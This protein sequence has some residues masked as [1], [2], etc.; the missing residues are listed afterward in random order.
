MAAEWAHRHGQNEMI[1]PRHR[2][3]ER[4]GGLSWHG[5]EQDVERVPAI[6]VHPAHMWSG[7]RNGMALVD[8]PH[9]RFLDPQQGGSLREN[10]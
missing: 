10:H 6:E 3:R 9:H 5:L 2:D 8:Y 7:D 4:E 1:S